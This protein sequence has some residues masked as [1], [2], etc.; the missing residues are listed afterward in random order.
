MN[1]PKIEEE[2]ASTETQVSVPNIEN[3]MNSI[4]ASL[5]AKHQNAIYQQLLQLQNT[6]QQDMKTIDLNNQK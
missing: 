6:L 4:L 2:N 3:M 1:Q 5:I